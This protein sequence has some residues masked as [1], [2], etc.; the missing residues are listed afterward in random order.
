[1]PTLGISLI[2]HNEAAMLGGAL[3]S[4]AFADEIVLVDC[5]S[6]DQT[7][8]IARSFPRVR[9]FDRPN[10]P[11]LNVNKTFG[12][13]QLS[14]DWIFYLDPD[15]RIPVDLARELNTLLG[16]TPH[17]AFRLPRRNF[18]FG[19]WLQ[20][21]GQYPDRQLRI[22]R[23]G[24]ASFPQKHVHESLEITGSIGTLTE[25]FDHHPYPTLNDYIRKM[26]FYTSFQASYWAARQT[27]ATVLM[28]LHQM[29]VRPGSRFLRRYL[30]KQ[31]FRDGWQGFVAALGDAFQN[32]I[33]FGKFLES[34]PK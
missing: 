16:T 20:Y 4:A 31:G 5:A 27:P 33:S 30:F 10:N 1:M 23:R 28:T 3:E 18:F 25:P 9:V 12:F 8:A 7:G 6:T 29:G 11:N 17:D 15:E 24:K 19:R 32:V 26:N 34:L 13:E 14:T 22:F 2:A 21:G